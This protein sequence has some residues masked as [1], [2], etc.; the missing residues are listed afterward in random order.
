LHYSTLPPGIN[1]FA[2]N[3]NNNNNNNRRQSNTCEQH[4]N[5]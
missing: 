1:L 2:V 3:N 4:V 5:S